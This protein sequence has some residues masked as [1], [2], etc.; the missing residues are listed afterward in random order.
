MF[1][2]FSE[3]LYR[4]FGTGTLKDYVPQFSLFTLLS[5]I[6][7]TTIVQIRVPELAMPQ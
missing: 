6:D 1:F 5:R 7:T 4:H 3:I 2:F